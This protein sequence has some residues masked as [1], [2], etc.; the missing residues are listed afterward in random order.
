MAVLGWRLPAT[1]LAAVPLIGKRLVTE[2]IIARADFSASARVPKPNPRAVGSSGQ[3]PN[4]RAGTGD[5]RSG[6]TP[7]PSRVCPSSNIRV[8][9]PWRRQVGAGPRL[10]E[11]AGEFPARH[12]P[13]RDKP[14]AQHRDNPAADLDWDRWAADIVVPPPAALR[15]SEPRR[16]SLRH[17]G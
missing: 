13:G 16:Q 8:A 6:R 9:R 10:A 11:V 3:E 15:S 14:A 4:S 7:I 5:R 17:H 1:Q 2:A 12:I